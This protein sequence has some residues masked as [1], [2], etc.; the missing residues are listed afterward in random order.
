MENLP[1]QLLPGPV[2]RLRLGGLEEVIQV[3][4]V[5]VLVDADRVPF[6]RGEVGQ[7]PGPLQALNEFVLLMLRLSLVSH[8][9]LRA[10]DR[11]LKASQLDGEM[12]VLGGG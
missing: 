8:D 7:T 9:E 5:A 12:T 2:D 6:S 1:T 3:W 10:I 4:E 11:L